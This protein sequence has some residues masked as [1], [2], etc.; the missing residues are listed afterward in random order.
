MEKDV[1]I[2]ISVTFR[3]T[4]SSDALKAYATDKITHAITKFLNQHADVHVVMNIEKRDHIVEVQILSKGYDFSTKA[5][6]EDLY[7]AIDKAVDSIE[8]QLR[9]QKERKIDRKHRAAEAV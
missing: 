1:D 4:N 2:N 9:K 5:V 3:H 7:S 8:T 6:T